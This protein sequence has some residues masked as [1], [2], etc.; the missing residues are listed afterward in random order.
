MCTVRIILDWPHVKAFISD[1]QKRS[2]K[3]KKL[4]LNE[5]AAAVV[6]QATTEQPREVLTPVD[7]DKNPAA[8]AL[9]HLGG[10]KGSKAR[11]EHDR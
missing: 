2:R 4:N 10:K 1:R 11:A 5:L 9:G 3:G 8:V 7:P 6:E